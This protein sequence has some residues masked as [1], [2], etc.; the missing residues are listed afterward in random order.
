VRTVGGSKW[1][2]LRQA[3][4]QPKASPEMVKVL[5]DAGASDAADTPCDQ[6]ALDSAIL[7]STVAV[8]RALLAGGLDPNACNTLAEALAVWESKPAMVMALLEAGADPNV[9]M[10]EWSGPPLMTVKSPALVK[11]LVDSGADV[12]WVN[13]SNA[14]VLAKHL[15]NCNMAG[16]DAYDNVSILLDAGATVTPEVRNLAFSFR[17]SD[18][19]CSKIYDLISSR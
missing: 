7:H 16:A 8:V 18:P 2:V 10:N 9:P 3:V 19:A 5:L 12:N 17:D 11:A 14:S 15:L 6:Q 13:G 4:V 1:S